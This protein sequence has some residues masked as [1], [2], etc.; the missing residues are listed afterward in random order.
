[1]AIS[2]SIKHET[3]AMCVVNVFVAYLRL[4]H[5]KGVFAAVRTGLEDDHTTDLVIIQNTIHLI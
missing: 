1:M 2:L 5:K 4:V 3:S